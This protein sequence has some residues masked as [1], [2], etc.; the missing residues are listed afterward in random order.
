MGLVQGT[1][2]VVD[3]QGPY[4][5]Y[6]ESTRVPPGLFGGRKNRPRR[7]YCRECFAT[8]FRALRE[9]LS[10][11]EGSKIARFNPFLDEGFIRLGGRLQYAKLSRE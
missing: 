11:P 5:V 3:R 8:E 6:L 7:R 4:P 10:L 9:N 1:V 2:R